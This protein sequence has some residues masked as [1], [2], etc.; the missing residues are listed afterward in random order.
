MI[1]LFVIGVFLGG[2]VGFMVGVDK[3]RT[4][5]ERAILRHVTESPEYEDG[6]ADTFFQA[7]K[8]MRRE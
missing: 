1:I 8:S 6:L 5:L 2:V 3:G 4:Y 7:F